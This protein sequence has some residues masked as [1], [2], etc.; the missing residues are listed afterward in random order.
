MSDSDTKDEAFWSA[1][2]KVKF[3]FAMT[4]EG[5][6]LFNLCFNGAI[7]ESL[8]SSE[9]MDNGCFTIWEFHYYFT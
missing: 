6:I 4:Q 5:V 1:Q 2:R 9:G 7:E 3:Y 8:F